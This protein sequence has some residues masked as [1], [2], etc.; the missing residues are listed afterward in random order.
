MND[1]SEWKDVN[2]ITEDLPNKG[3]TII[4]FIVGGLA[5]G[6]LGIVGMRVRPLGLAIGSFAFVTGIG[7]ILRAIKQKVSTNIKTAV[8]IT[9]AGFLMLLANPRFGVVAGFAAYFVIVGAIGLVVMG[10]SKA[11]KL[12][13]DL[14]KRS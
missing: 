14:Q 2:P 5:L 12:A 11:I 10:L 13:W 3:R 9:V 6:L 1:E 8:I 4:L 7:M